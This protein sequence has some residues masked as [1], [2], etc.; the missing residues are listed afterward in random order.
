[1]LLVGGLYPCVLARIIETGMFDVILP[2]EQAALYCAWIARKKNAAALPKIVYYSLEV[3]T[4]SD[5]DVNSSLRCM[6]LE[7]RRIIRHVDGIIIQD[8]N[9]L[10]VLGKDLAHTIP[11]I[12]LIPLFSDRPVFTGIS[13]TLHKT[14]GIDQRKKVVLY[15]GAFYAE[16]MLEAIADTLRRAGR[17]DIVLVLHIPG[18]TQEQSK[19]LR[20][21]NNEL[22]LSTQFL[23]DDELDALVASADVGLALY[24]N[25]KP[26]TRFTAFS[27][28][29]IATYLRCGVPFIAFDNESYRELAA[30]HNCCA[31]IRATDELIIG[32]DRLS[33]N[34]EQFAH[35]AHRAYQSLFF[36]TQLEL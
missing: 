19:A 25:D 26:N 9:R 14:F 10:N 34:R 8:L 24:D 4:P 32:I 33:N 11:A 29:K 17:N 6:L 1:M 23:S 20:E 36:R 16:R 35:D 15:F 12:Y 2:V 18:L 7:E 31:L 22:I 3:Q 27:S 5:A 21:I 30:R 13:Q 28:E